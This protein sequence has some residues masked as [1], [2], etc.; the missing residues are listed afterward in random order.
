MNIWAVGNY[1]NSGF[2]KHLLVREIL[3]IQDGT[4]YI[5]TSSTGGLYS[6]QPYRGTSSISTYDLEQLHREAVAY[7]ARIALQET[8]ARAR[9][10][11]IESLFQ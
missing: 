4:I 5:L 2:L 10:Y 1:V 9:A 7:A 11:E 6:H 3:K 8:R